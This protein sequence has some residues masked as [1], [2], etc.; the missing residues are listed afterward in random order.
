MAYMNQERKA[1]IAKAL[2]P[3]MKKYGIK[4]TLSVR[5]HSTIVL[6]VKSG[7]IDFIKN[8]NDVCG[9]SFYHT[10]RGFREI[11]DSHMSIN[12]YWFHEHFD[13]DA[14]NFLEEAFVALKSAGWYDRSDIQTDYFDVAYYTDIDIGKWDKPY[15]VK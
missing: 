5:N 14:K 9:K 8:M 12:P 4:G 7:K 13:G 2:A 10:T 1:V 11:T 3:V 6:N 15:I